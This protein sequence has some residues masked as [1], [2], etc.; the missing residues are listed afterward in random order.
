MLE[1]LSPIANFYI[2]SNSEMAYTTAIVKNVINKYKQYIPL[3]NVFSFIPLNQ[4]KEH[5]ETKDLELMGLGTFNTI[6]VDDQ[7]IVWKKKYRQNVIVSLKF[8]P[9]LLDNALQGNSA[10]SLWIDGKSFTYDEWSIFEGCDQTSQLSNI[11]SF[12]FKCFI[13]FNHEHKS[14]A[15]IMRKERRSILRGQKFYIG[16]DPNKNEMIS[17][18]IRELGGHISVFPENALHIAL[19]KE[20]SEEDPVKKYSM[21]YLLFSYI[22]IAKLN[23][24]GFCYEA[25]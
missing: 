3:E 9:L 18:L 8:A 19:P 22:Y 11:S 20:K 2:R 16:C 5:N 10:L 24:E 23:I 17:A 13:E 4:S 7:I 6:I 15:N 12:I 14:V 21:D 25:K 1:K